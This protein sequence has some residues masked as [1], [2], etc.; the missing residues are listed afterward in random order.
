M[1]QNNP[2]NPS[3]FKRQAV[4]LIENPK[5]KVIEHIKKLIEKI[6]KVK[7]KQLQNITKQLT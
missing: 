1:T 7:P 5:R 6:K 2:I 4:N 3:T